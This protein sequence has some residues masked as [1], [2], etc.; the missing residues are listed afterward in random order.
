MVNFYV[1]KVFTGTKKWNEIPDLWKQKVMDK[2]VEDGY[3]LNDDGS[4]SIEVQNLE[5]STNYSPTMGVKL[6]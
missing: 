4:V 1:Y 6:G 5:S 3:V 2:L